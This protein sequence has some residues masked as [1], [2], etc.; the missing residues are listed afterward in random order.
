MINYLVQPGDMLGVLAVKYQTTIETLMGDNPFIP[1]NQKLT[2][3]WILKIYTPQENVE[4]NADTAYTSIESAQAVE[5]VIRSTDYF[6]ATPKA[7]IYYKS[8]LVEDGMVAFIRTTNPTSLYELEMDGFIKL[9]RNVEAGEIFGVFQTATLEGNPAFIVNGYNWIYDDPSILFDPIPLQV[10]NGAISLGNQGVTTDKLKATI[11]KSFAGFGPSP[12]PLSAYKIQ[13]KSF[14]GF[15]PPQNTQSTHQVSSV[16]QAFE[17]RSYKRPLLQL[18]N[19]AQ[20]TTRMELRLTGF[21][22]SYVNTVTPQPTNAGWM[23]NVRAPELPV[24]NISGYLLET[25]ASNEFDDF[26]ARYHKYLEA[27]K[28]GD[29]YSMG[30]SILTYKSTEYRGV[31]NS[32]SY[33][34]NPEAP[35]HRE[36][37]MQMLVLREKTLTSTQINNLPMVVSR[38]GYASE[39]DFRSDLGAM[40][41]NPIVGN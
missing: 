23:V 26:M 6:T 30:I 24:L 12:T 1:A 17:S 36:Y 13:P 4:R 21:S 5:E 29:F 32:F 25:V 33:T 9:V 19:A 38:K 31:I 20:E 11:I 34:D 8:R 37:T 16:V 28:S 35:L 10:L 27:S 15:G 40:L 3:G 7:P 22:A 14:V 18:T 41:A 39:E 2:A